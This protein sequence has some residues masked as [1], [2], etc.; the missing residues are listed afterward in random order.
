MQERERSE[1]Q[2]G[3]VFKEKNSDKLFLKSHN[4]C[5]SLKKKYNKKEKI[6]IEYIFLILLKNKYIKLSNT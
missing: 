4:A 1:Y 6:C 2:C 5:S 3:V